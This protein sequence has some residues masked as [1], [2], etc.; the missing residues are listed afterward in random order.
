MLQLEKLKS[1]AAALEA[2]AR[3]SGHPLKHCAALEKVAREHGYQNWRAC[4]AATSI[5]KPEE[6][7]EA[8]NSQALDSEMKHYRSTEWTFGLDIP[9]RWNSFPAVPT[10]SPY[11]VIRFASH[12]DGNHLLIVFRRPY[13]PKR[14]DEAYL[15]ELT[16]GLAKAGFSNFVPGETDIASRRVTTLDFDKPFDK[17]NDGETWS[18][19]HYF[20][21]NGTLVYTLGF[22]TNRRDAMFDL[23]DRIANSFVVDDSR[24]SP[25]N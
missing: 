10:N 17:S 4:I 20:I 2:E 12:E 21:V 15:G 14:G 1:E 6:L 5:S 23:Y 13:D 18:C 25:S 8:G 7:R 24:S 11:E 3:A 19:R 9:S 22:G 16:G